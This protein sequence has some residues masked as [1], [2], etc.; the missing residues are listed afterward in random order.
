MT[1]Y[2]IAPT[3]LTSGAQYT[4]FNTRPRS[5]A[6]TFNVADAAHPSTGDCVQCHN[7]TNYFSATDKPANHIPTATSAQC[8]ACHTNP[9]FSVL[10]TL[11]NIHA[12]A[13][14]TTS[15][16]AQCH[17]ASVVAGFAIPSANFTIVGPPGNHI[18]TSAA[19]ELCHVGAG[20]SVSATPV[21]NGA[22]F[23]GS[24]MNHSGITSNCV[25]CHGPGIT[26]SS[27]SG[28]T[29]IVAMPP[30]SPVGASSHIPS[31]TTCE[32]CHL[33]TVPAG[34][35]AANATKTAPGTAFATPAPTTAQIHAGITSGCSSCHDTSFVWMG[36]S[37]YPISPTT[38][39]AS[40]Q[41]TGFH[42]RPTAAGGTFAVV[43]AAHPTTGDCSQCHSG[44]N[45]FSAQAKP[46]GHIPTSQPCTTCHVTAGDFS[47]AGLTT[48]L[49]TLH[50]GI[51]S[52]CISCHSAGTGAGPFAGCTTQATC[53]ATPPLTYQPKTTPLAA[54]GSPTAPSSQTHVPVV[55]ISCEKCHS[56]TVFTSFAGM[57]MKGNTNAHTAVAA[58]TCESCHEYRYTW[59][60]VTITTPG[61]VNHNGRT[62]G[63][64][65]ISSGCHRKSYSSFSI[66]ARVK[67]V[68]R[69]ALAGGPAMRVLP[70]DA[71][72]AGADAGAS[73]A[74]NHQGVLPGQCA[75]CHNGRAARGLPAK[76]L[77]TRASCDSCHRTTAW[78][79]AQFSHLGS[80][81][82][83]CN[84]CHNGASATGK[85]A[86]HFVT[87]RS[88]DS[89][90]RTVGWTPVL[91]SH[92]SPAYHPMPDKST[93]V[94]CHITNGEIIPRQLRGGP[95]PKPTPG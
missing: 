57:Q 74:F 66:L 58:A 69:S 23:S 5:A 64:D 15:N 10:P 89:C 93:C 75:T 91:Y 7:G 76:H 80:M 42:S 35:I 43:D 29:K 9:D 84:T 4:G 27:F 20:S 3:T 47:V 46:A 25:A 49:T 85:P 60:G 45:F 1:A 88:C 53:P 56:P 72:A 52:G 33:A 71:A 14:S 87:V 78:V 32:S 68:Q 94:S 83:Q 31:S 63:E 92:L 55:G 50:T 21:P 67:P 28:I 8:T 54:G 6:G 30:T 18:P 86:G 2:P 26:G 70:D 51:S 62:A 61:S 22:K 65:C 24:L 41:Y 48:N 82:G 81:Q 90:H 36:M 13:P 16:C 38:V 73:P 11:A 39:V 40:A 44:T 34:M 79:P 12:N 37:A 77:M 17:A 95:R 59:Y 19:C